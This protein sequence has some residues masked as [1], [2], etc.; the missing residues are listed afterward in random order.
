MA[1]AGQID[2][3]LSRFHDVRN[4]RGSPSR[5]VAK[6]GADARAKS[7]ALRIEVSARCSHTRT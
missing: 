1:A 3:R 5:S 6:A 4:A 7:G 2:G